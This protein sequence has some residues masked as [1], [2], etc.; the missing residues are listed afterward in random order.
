MFVVKTFQTPPLILNDLPAAD[1][2]NCER[3]V[4][5]GL[6][7]AGSDID[8]GTRRDGHDAGFP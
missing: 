8:R 7:E 5:F 2:P 1:L 4:S 3:Q 6:A